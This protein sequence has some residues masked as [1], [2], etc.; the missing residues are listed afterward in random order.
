MRRYSGE[1]LNLY[2]LDLYRLEGD[3]KTQVKELGIEDFW[4]RDGNVAVIEWADKSKEIFPN[5][6][7]WINFEKINEDERKISVEGL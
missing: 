2:H 5:E 7:V 1:K 4:G 3:I 6:T